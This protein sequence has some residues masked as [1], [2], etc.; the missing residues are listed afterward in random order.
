MKPPRDRVVLV[1]GA[2]SGIGRAVA[3]AFHADG[4]RVVLAARRSERLAELAATLGPRA[5]AVPC[6]VRERSQ[7]RA[8]VARAVEAFG[9][10]HVAV[11]NAG[12]GCYS[13]VSTL[14]DADL[15]A[16][17][18]TNLYGVLYT[19]QE[20]L[21]EL[22][23]NRGQAILVTSILGKAATP[24][25]G[26]YSMTKHAVT[27]LADALRMEVRDDGVDVI[28]VGPG[29]T[30]TEFQQAAVN[31]AGRAPVFD[32]AKGWPPERVARAVLSASRR[33]RREVYLTLEGRALISLRHWAPGLADLGV[34]MVL[35]TGRQP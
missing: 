25:T 27:A 34:R 31:R 12:V 26:P 28:T 5:I 6:D 35:G 4:A 19:V 16:V 1:T 15:D 30:R 32:N 23:R 10:L 9:A 3:E 18:R 29:L 22:R 20:A 8:A 7:V 14:Q 2:S 33:R 17:L 13:A 11:A 21:P 24:M